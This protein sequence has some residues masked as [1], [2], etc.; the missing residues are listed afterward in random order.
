M[1]SIDIIFT[2]L[3]Y[4]NMK[5]CRI[6][7]HRNLIRFP[8]TA[9]YTTAALRRTIIIWCSSTVLLIKPHL[10]EQKRYLLCHPERAV[11]SLR[12]WRGAEKMHMLGRY[13]STNLSRFL[14][15]SSW[16]HHG[17]RRRHRPLL[18]FGAGGVILVPLDLDIHVF[19]CFITIV[20]QSKDI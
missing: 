15:E 20:F 4:T 10:V 11:A 8:I 18:W 14:Q 3:Y 12:R 17:G 6:G 19:L 1:I 9:L 13:S 5:N 7:F 16:H 2:L